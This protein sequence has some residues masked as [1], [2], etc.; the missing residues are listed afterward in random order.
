VAG[1]ARALI[2]I[3]ALI[4]LLAGCSNEASVPRSATTSPGSASSSPTGNGKFQPTDE[5][6][7]A[8]RKLLDR[9][10]QALEKGDRK[11]FMATVDPGNKV[12][13]H[14]QGLV[15]D[16]LQKLPVEQVGYDVDDASGWVPAKV[17]GNDPVFRPRV[18]EQVRLDIDTRSVTNVVENTFV[19]RDGTWLLGAESVPGKYADDD[20]QWRPWGGAVPIAVARTGRLIVVVDEKRADTAGDLAAEMTDYI[21][22][23][24]DALDVEPQYDVLV[25]AT[26]VG[27][28]LSMSTLKD[29]QAA[30]VSRTVFSF[31]IEEGHG[32]A[33]A[34]IV[35]NPE[36]TDRIVTDPEIMRHEL[37]HYLT[38]RRLAAAPS[39]VVEGIAEWASTAP[40]SLDDLRIDA[41]ALKHTLGTHHRL[42]TT[43]VWGIDPTADYL[44]ARA[45][46]TR[47]VDDYGVE[48]VFEMGE[49]YR[50]ISGDDPDE[51]SDRVIRKVL[52]ISKDELVRL[53]FADLAAMQTR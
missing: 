18:L 44:I 41:D 14:Q 42:P 39:W 25:D 3:A 52:G 35:V 4:G 13:M 45:A 49:T 30:A 22:F 43:G 24:A 32:I 48:K 28:A 31:G 36:M 40:A 23:V 1:D 34:R 37:T 53:A 2:A 16:N 7:A 38:A 27:D 29:E 20:A 15:F 12:L 17:K 6:R 10:A 5:D 8:I 46:V 21:G 50:R 11:A 26:S 33:G 9:R 51:K 19:R 47:I